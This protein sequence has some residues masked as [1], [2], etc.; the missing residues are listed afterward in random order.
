MFLLSYQ[1][2]T[3]YGW[4][5]I[6]SNPLSSSTRERRPRYQYQRGHCARKVTPRQHSENDVTNAG[7]ELDDGPQPRDRPGRAAPGANRTNVDPYADCDDDGISHHKPHCHIV[8]EQLACEPCWREYSYRR[9]AYP[10]PSGPPGRPRGGE[11]IVGS[12]GS[13]RPSS[14]SVNGTDS[15]AFLHGIEIVILALVLV[16]ADD[17]EANRGE[18]RSILGGSSDRDSNP[19]MASFHINGSASDVNS[20]RPPGTRMSAIL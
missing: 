10:R 13:L 3:N 14:G 4:R 18:E 1:Q 12:G 6:D 9:V 8:A 7:R 11:R 19:V 20:R 15:C 16:L 5:F 17:R 2:E